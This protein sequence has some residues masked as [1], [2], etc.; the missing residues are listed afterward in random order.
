MINLLNKIINDIS[1]TPENTVIISGAGISMASG[2]P[3]GGNLTK[4]AIEY[5]GFKFQDV[6][7][8]FETINKEYIKPL[9]N[10]NEIK[11]YSS[12]RLEAIYNV[13]SRSTA[14][15]SYLSRIVQKK[16]KL[17]DS[18]VTYLLYKDILGKPLYSN[19][20]HRLL[21]KTIHDKGTVITLNF[22]TLI[23]NAYQ[24]LYNSSPTVISFPLEEHN[25]S[26]SK[27]V[28]VK[29]HGCITKPSG[30]GV[31]LDKLSINGFA[32]NSH[33][34]SCL[35]NIFSNKIN[36]VF[37]GYSMSDSFDITPYLANLKQSFNFIYFNYIFSTE[38]YYKLPSATTA[39]GFKITDLS[40]SKKEETYRYVFENILSQKQ[41]LNLKIVNYTDNLRFFDDICGKWTGTKSIQ[42]NV[43]LPIVS[44]IE[45]NYFK[46]RLYYDFGLSEYTNFHVDLHKEKLQLLLSQKST[47]RIRNYLLSCM[48]NREKHWYILHCLLM[49]LNFV[50]TPHH[51]LHNIDRIVGTNIELVFV[52]PKFYLKHKL[53]KLKTYI[54]QTIGIVVLSFSI[55][56]LGILLHITDYCKKKKWLAR[57]LFSPESYLTSK[58]SY[59]QF[60]HCICRLFVENAKPIPELLQ[61]KCKT[62]LEDCKNL[63]KEY[64]NLKELRYIKKNDI[65]FSYWTK[66]DISKEEIIDEFNELIK[67]DADTDYFVEVRNVSRAKNKFIEEYE[68]KNNH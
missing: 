38:D 9:T 14:E 16:R 26:T 43:D 10:G 48:F 34:K 40:H 54:F 29:A 2:L 36:V 63:A 51:I 67:F 66:D 6:N 24:E 5:L 68:K 45:K 7:D 27:N 39:Y 21:A 30:I 37:I 41:I 4:N 3:S 60:F 25:V 44:E 8:V 61:N 47:Y 50:F 17:Y 1:F 19:N 11:L 59:Q 55:P 58:R 64:N 53:G 22:D 57:H 18:L 20:Y 33:E 49:W 32:D 56:T 42:F 13:F 31:A 35:D 65:I 15:Y 52:A 23:E 46:L 62:T 28:L 12:P